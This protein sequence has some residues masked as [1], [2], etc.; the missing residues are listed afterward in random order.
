VSQSTAAPNYTRWFLISLGVLLLAVALWNVRSILL[1]ALAASIVV[2]FI[3]IPVQKLA[4]LGMRRGPAILLTIVSG[5]ALLY[6]VMLLVLPALTNQFVTLATETIPAGVEA[7]TEFLTSGELQE[8]FP[9]LEEIDLAEEFPVDAEMLR[10]VGERVLEALTRVGGSVLPFLGGVANT[11]LSIVI[12]IFLSMFFLAEPDRYKQGLVQLFPLWYRDRIQ[13][14]LDRLNHLLRRWLFAQMIGMTVT[15]VGTFVGLTLVGI[16]EAG[17]L[18]VLA[19]FFSFVPNFGE[20]LT[21]LV[22]LAVGVVQVPDRL[23][24]IVLVIYGVA[25]VQNQLIG[26]LIASETVNIPPVLIL[27]GQIIV[28][29]FFGVL[30]LILAVPIM[31][32]TMVL[33]Q[34]IYIK[35]ILGDR[36]KEEA[37]PGGKPDG[38]AP[39]ESD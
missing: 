38:E 39:A 21:V 13:H 4:R 14:I 1:L 34:E 36:G 24:L 32:I 28:A 29:G 2:I 22:A 5:I 8:R 19:A 31:V 23:L 3:S 6:L 25:F 9:F 35:D 37:A 18:A 16:P 11:L 27:L 33:I 17:A 10:E 12:V 20:L 7:I 30:G 15:G 26:P